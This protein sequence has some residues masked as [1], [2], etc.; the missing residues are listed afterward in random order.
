MP[1][2]MDS[3]QRARLFSEL[4][5]DRDYSRN[6]H[7]AASPTQQLHDAGQGIDTVSSFSPEFE[8]TNQI[9]NVSQH[10]LPQ[11]RSTAQRY[12]YY[13][14]PQ[15]E[16]H[17]DTSAVRNGFPGFSEDSN[18]MSIE[19]GRGVKR[20][21]R[22]SPN[23]SDMS[24]DP[25]QN[26]L[27]SLG[28]DSNYEIT[29]TPPI[30]QRTAARRS[31]DFERGSL[32]KEASIRRAI[33]VPETANAFA[34]ISDT[35]PLA[36]RNANMVPRRTL[37]DMHAK[38]TAEARSPLVG[39]KRPQCTTTSNVRNTRFS[40]PSQIS[41]I[42]N[43]FPSKFSA[44]HGLE[45]AQQ[46]PRR[47]IANMTA[48]NTTIAGTQTQAS[49]MLPD[50]PN[51][52]E[53]V[54]GARKD[55]TPVFS[56]S[57]KSRSRFTSG[58]YVHKPQHIGLAA[59]PVPEEEKVIFASLQL[60]KDK[61]EQLEVEIS[62]AQGK[63]NE[64]ESQV[65]DLKTQLQ[66]EKRL[67]RPDSV[68][69]SEEEGR[70][71]DKWR[72]EKIRLE[73]TAKSLQDRVSLTERKVAVS[74]F[75]VKRITKERDSLV[76]Q[77][78]VAFYNLEELKH[79]NEAIQCSTNQL[80]LDNDALQDENEALRM[81]NGEF[82]VRLSQLSAQHQD[83][84]EPWTR[85]EAMSRDKTGRREEAVKGPRDVRPDV[86]DSGRHALEMQQ[87][88]RIRNGKI[89]ESATAESRMGVTGKR[90]SHGRLGQDTQRGIAEKVQQ[91][92]RRSRSD[93]VA[94]PGTSFQS[95]PQQLK[96]LPQTRSGSDS[97]HHESWASLPTYERIPM[98]RTVPFEQQR[99]QEEEVSDAES[100]TDLE[101]PRT[102]TVTREMK[103]PSQHRHSATE[104][105]ATRDITYLSFLDGGEIA[106]LRQTLEEE[107]RASRQKRNSS[108][109]VAV[110]QENTKNTINNSNN[111]RP[112]TIPRK[113]S[114]KDVTGTL[115]NID[116]DGERNDSGRL[117]LPGEAA[118]ELSRGPKAV[119]IQSP[120]NSDM[121]SQ[122]DATD[123]SIM[124]N[125]SRRRRR[126]QNAKE[127]GM[128]SAFILPDIT[129]HARSVAAEQSVEVSGKHDQ[130]NCTFCPAPT[131][132]D[133]PIPI[134]VP[135]T[136]R[137][138]DDT[139]ATIR[140]SQSPTL[141]LATV[142][143]QLEDEIAHLKMQLA[144]YEKA[145]NA[146]DPALGK[147]KRLAMKAKIEEL[148]REVERR[149]EQVYG[150]YDVVEGQKAAAEVQKN[151]ENVAKEKE[152]GGKVDGGE[153]VEET[154][155]SFEKDLDQLRSRSERIAGGLGGFDGAES[156]EDLPFE[157]S[158]ED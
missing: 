77:L 104:Q 102:R 80:R 125:S 22:N 52:T 33:T 140:P 94:R 31:G 91:E 48:N 89:G 142:L 118:D 97:R 73:A 43:S 110:Q 88:L 153:E 1:T 2:S 20:S 76:T 10:P 58:S 5:R 107:R 63:I 96:N 27:F 109:P 100:T 17:V 126:A 62:E 121:F 113:S 138:I 147:R 108:A 156:E 54:S 83:G 47:T 16:Q 59:I 55:G 81:E 66:V 69:G 87:G 95:Q 99:T 24:G 18:S 4:S 119:R 149:S 92:V 116:A 132:E 60:L 64:Y 14:P 61:V 3:E 111:P 158:D 6:S 79:E 145:Y 141:A 136:D 137:N 114:L 78:G 82:R 151:D 19:L 7:S 53:L 15:P 148:I 98:S 157:G 41:G 57:T 131:Q 42:E 67:R 150:L 139:F 128:T 39:E 71:N 135:V 37:S 134:P 143:K 90:A 85:T 101:I 56:R 68:L 115:R 30:R 117:S 103:Q 11:M 75:A 105:D 130:H 124:S 26:V 74:E 127:E 38:V 9:D 45:T 32:R 36:T 29:G 120:H 112:Y 25:S 23:K 84:I 50:L 21:A 12:G 146:H 40:K 154:L 8:S 144:R 65:V 72:M 152:D 93:S 70:A 44:A 35:V 123:V 28:D 49:F 129:L 46:T 133:I 86:F 51:I 13:N 106:K 34:K 122:K 155:Q